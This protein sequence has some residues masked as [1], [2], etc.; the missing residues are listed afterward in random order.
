MAALEAAFK[1]L[2]DTGVPRGAGSARANEIYGSCG[3]V[4]QENIGL[5]RSQL[6][7]RRA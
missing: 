5:A 7:L 6:F 3:L 1:V 2:K 4:G